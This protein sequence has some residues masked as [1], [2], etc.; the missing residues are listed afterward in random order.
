MS[1]T[2]S[3]NRP[4]DQS[5]DTLDNDTLDNSDA[6]AIKHQMDAQA[7]SAQSQ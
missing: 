7:C 4:L 1:R 6:T 3:T 2:M 5:S